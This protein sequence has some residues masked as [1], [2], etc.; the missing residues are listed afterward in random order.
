MPEN[1]VF[2]RSEGGGTITPSQAN[3]EQNLQH[4]SI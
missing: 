4:P 2:G 3:S 1:Q